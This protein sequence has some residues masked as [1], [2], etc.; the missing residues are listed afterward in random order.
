MYFTLDIGT[1]N[2]RLCLYSHGNLVCTKKMAIGAGSTKTFGKDFLFKKLKD[3]ILSILSENYIREESVAYIFASGMAGSEL[4]LCE[5]PH[6]PLPVNVCNLEQHIQTHTLS[7]ITSIPIAFV[8]GIKKVQDNMLADIMRG[9]E[10]ESIGIFNALSTHEDF[11]LVL[12]GTHNKV[13]C[14]RSDGTITDFYST[15]SGE[16][17]H[18]IISNS[19]LT[20]QV[21]HDFEI[22]KSAV[23]HGAQYAAENG[24]HATLFHVRV[25]AMNKLRKD[26]LCSFL[27]GAVISQD[28][29]KIRHFSTGKPIYIGG[30]HELKDTYGILLGD[31]AI[32]L[33]SGICEQAVNNGI[34]AIRQIYLARQ[35]T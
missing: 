13:I 3:L 16:V 15:M 33:S 20:G 21:D 19:I 17:L 11:V 30:R 9:E 12:P 24:L 23:L 18:N 4:G 5:I 22:E 35:K 6:I 26:T 8:P 31:N 29:E 2:T 32:K 7:Q 34:A 27:Y 1:S 25:M 28:I 14:V 10:V